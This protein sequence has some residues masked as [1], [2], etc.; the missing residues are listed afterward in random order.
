VRRYFPALSAIGL[1]GLILIAAGIAPRADAATRDF[2]FTRLGSD[3]GLTQN[4]VTA[5]AQD[6][7]GFVWV[8]TQGG[9]HRYD[10][11][12]YVAFRHDPRDPG[13]LPDSFVTALA[14]EGDQALWIGTYS[15]YVARL[16][17][18]NGRIR[19]YSITDGEHANRQVMAVLPSRGA[20]WVGT[21]AGLERLDAAS[22]RRT[23]VVRLNPQTTRE[24]PWQ[25]LLAARD[26]TIWFASNAGLYRIAPNGNADR[27]GPAEP[28][29][30][31][32]TGSS[33][34]VVDRSA[35]MVCTA[36]TATAAA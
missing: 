7:Q 16:D 12:R 27:V 31:P 25:N 22:G 8:G 11:Q 1:L 24:A 36:C 19:R 32:P 17:L 2:Y 30:Q 21:V 6:R 33:R 5:L 3:R 18:R 14:V 34:P 13:T 15:E 35:T 28:G 10:G 23:L 4:T 26:G 9:L 29:A 20:L